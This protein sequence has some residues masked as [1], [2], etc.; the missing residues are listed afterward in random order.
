MGCDFATDWSPNGRRILF[1][2]ECAL[3]NEVWWVSA[4][5]EHDQRLSTEGN[6]NDPDAYSSDGHWVDGGKAVVYYKNDYNRDVHGVF[7]VRP[8]TTGRRRLGPRMYVDDIAVSPDGRFVAFVGMPYPVTEEGHRDVWVMG[9]DGSHLVQVTDDAPAEAGLEWSPDGA[10]LVFVSGDQQTMIVTVG[11][12]GSGRRALE[13][14]GMSSE[15]FREYDPHWSPDGSEIVFLAERLRMLSNDFEY[16]AYVVAA[17]GS[18]YRRVT[19][20]ERDLRVWGW[21]PLT[22]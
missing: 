17:D 11:R 9:S 16:A 14:V 6:R 19:E 20:F 15:Y 5:G 3:C 13:P 22:S 12:D 18:Y 8:D 7:R 10:T 4:D 2:H 1:D 21:K